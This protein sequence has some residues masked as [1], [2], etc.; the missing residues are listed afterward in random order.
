M[1]KLLEEAIEQARELPVEEQD[2]AT[3]ALFAYISNDER[4]YVLRP[5][6]VADVRRI[7]DALRKGKTRLATTAEVSALRKKTY[8]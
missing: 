2:G 8:L 4:Q 7:Q 1:T 3:D 6:Q 5:D